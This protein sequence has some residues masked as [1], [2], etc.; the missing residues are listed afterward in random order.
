M[1]GEGSWS[2]LCQTEQ[3]QN[4]FSLDKVKKYSYNES[5]L[6]SCK[7]SYISIMLCEITFS[8]N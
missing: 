5:I 4:F 8:I 7:S 6:V 3:I 1:S 2:L